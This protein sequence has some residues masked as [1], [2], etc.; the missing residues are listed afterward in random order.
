M[1]DVYQGAYCNLAATGA[2]GGH[3]GLFHDRNVHFVQRCIVKANW[4]DSS[5]GKSNKD[6]DWAGCE[7]GL[8]ELRS[9]GFWDSELL[10][11]PLMQRAWVFQE[12]LL[13]PRVLH[14]GARQILWECPELEACE[15]YPEG[16]PFENASRN[17]RKGLNPIM[18]GARA[19]DRLVG[20][21]PQLDAVKFD[22]LYLWNSIIQAYSPGFL[23]NEGDKPIA[24]SGMA[25]YM[26]SLSHDIYIAG[27]WQRYLPSQLL[28]HYHPPGTR[29]KA[30]RAPSWSWAAVNPSINSTLNAGNI[31]DT[32]IVA[33][34][35]DVRV[36][37]ANGNAT[38]QVTGGYIRLRSLLCTIRFRKARIAKQLPIFSIRMGESDREFRMYE[39]A[40]EELQEPDGNGS[41]GE[42]HYMV[43]HRG[44]RTPDT[45][46]KLRGLV[47]LP[48]GSQKGQ[49]QRR[50]LLDV[51]LLENEDSVPRFAQESWLQYEEYHEYTVS[52]F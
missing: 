24:L 1:A 3:G 6:V 2:V 9:D 5:L 20:S 11:A 8:Y 48:T 10:R 17:F 16:L 52:I 43:V 4:L 30:Y 12:R 50:G 22:A 28:W 32:D 33:Q 38:G 26:Q 46:G 15:T 44:L 31:C 42:Y 14:F 13:A 36:D 27:L 41:G 45:V 39:D 19:R 25:K 47:L 35:L 29:P 7:K 18:D 23:T 37:T 49:F 34:V 21:L 40:V 51:D